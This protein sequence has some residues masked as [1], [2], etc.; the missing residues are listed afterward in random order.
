MKR[1][2]AHPSKKRTLSADKIAFA[3]AT[4]VVATLIGLILYL[5]VTQTDQPPILTIQQTQPIRAEQGQFY[6][7]FS[8]KNIGGKTAEAVQVVGE[9]KQGDRTIESGEQQIDF[10]S[11]FEEEEGA[12]LFSFDPRKADLKLRVASYKLP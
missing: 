3:I 10:L 6:V 11:S 8:L 2:F 1:T 5:W 7:P 4:L 9:L 12:F